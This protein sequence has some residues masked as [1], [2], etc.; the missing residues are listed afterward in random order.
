M[1]VEG[2]DVEGHGKELLLRAESKQVRYKENLLLCAELEQ[3]RVE[4]DLLL[5][6][7]PEQVQDEEA[8]AS[9]GTLARRRARMGT[10][11]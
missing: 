6:A 7:E 5:R 4:E 9:T 3:V 1:D 10:L 8:A 11:V 2:R